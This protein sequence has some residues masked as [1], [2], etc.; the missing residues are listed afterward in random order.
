L[1]TRNID[2]WWTALR[3]RNIVLST[4]C[5][6]IE[7]QV[8]VDRE[9][10]KFWQDNDLPNVYNGMMYFRYTRE[11]VEF[12]TLAR[13][14]FANYEYI[15]DNLLINCREERPSTDVIIFVGC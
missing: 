5:R 12:F 4:N 8:V 9:Y 2:H 6:N 13:Q 11:A 7:D 15:R 1:F 3:L 10:R 14:L